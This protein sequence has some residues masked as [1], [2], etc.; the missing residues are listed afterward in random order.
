MRRL[1]ILLSLALFV[2][3]LTPASAYK[4]L[5]PENPPIYEG[6]SWF[7][8]PPRLAIGLELERPAAL[9]LAVPPDGMLLLSNEA[10]DPSAGQPSRKSSTS[11][12]SAS[13]VSTTNEAPSGAYLFGPTT[14]GAVDPVV[15]L[16]DR[17]RAARRAL[18]D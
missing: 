8:E 3:A 17:V 16:E 9:P 12:Q 7:V 13:N 2:V 4:Y 11:A 14:G 5:P 15:V 10:G 1:P 18:E 6:P